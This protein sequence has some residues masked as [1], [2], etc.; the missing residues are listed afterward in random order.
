MLLEFSVANYRSFFEK[1]TFTMQASTGIGDSPDNVSRVDEY[2]VLRTAVVYG[3]NSSGKTN[4]VRAFVA[5]CN[6]VTNSA[7][8]NPTEELE[9]D[10]FLLKQTTEET[11]TYFEIVFI[12]DGI[13]Y[14]YGFEHTR[15]IVGEWLFSKKGKS[16]EKM[17]FM[18]NNEGIGVSKFDFREG[19]GLEEKTNDNR[20]FISVVAQLGG[21]ISKQIV[22]W[23]AFK[24][25]AISGVRSDG[26]AVF[27]KKMFH[28]K[29]TGHQE[30]L[31]FLQRLNLGF[32]SILTVEREF[33]PT[34]IPDGLSDAMKRE[35][36]KQW[37]GKKIVKLISTHKKYNN[38]GIIAGEI[39]FDVYERESEG[40]QKLIDLSGPI[41]DSLLKGRV[42]IIDEL[43]CRMHPIIS[44]HIVRLFNDKKTNPKNAQLIFTTH[45]TNLL[46]S[47]IFRRDQIW[48]AEKDDMEQTD[49]YTLND[50]VLPN[51][52]K[53]RNDSNYEKNYIAGRYGA[54]PFIQ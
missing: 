49:L 26:V 38:K 54:I 34:S 53:P 48:F 40:T 41:F 28:E 3:A 14:R 32:D 45:D 35:F 27:S 46:S 30:A 21:V 20:L 52:Q 23:F 43:D 8:L 50:I 5:M 33:D 31:H 24:F 10:I 4:L 13:Q 1:R 51:G 18:R 17:L 6:L 22:E 7:K 44:D 2:N 12:E 39:P 9:S 29:R 19:D 11:P 36:S 25:G 37:S 42:L 16:R 15:Q 47:K